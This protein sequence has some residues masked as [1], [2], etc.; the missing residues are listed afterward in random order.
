M[1]I[2]ACPDIRR[3]DRTHQGAIA[4]LLAALIVVALIGKAAASTYVV[5]IPLD[6]PIYVE[7]DTLNGLGLLD[8]YLP[9][10]RPISRIEA[11]RLVLEARDNLAREG[12][13]N[14][15]A[16]SLIARLRKQLGAE[17]SW[18][19]EDGEDN[20]PNLVHPF[21]R[22]EFG[23]LFSRGERRAMDNNGGGYIR[24][25]EATALLANGDGLSAKGEHNQTGR[26]SLWQ[27]FGGFFTAYG[28]GAVSGSLSSPGDSSARMLSG[29]AV[30]SLGNLAL[31]F[32]REEMA[33]GVGN[34]GQLSQSDNARPFPALRLR[35]IHADHLPWVFRYLGPYRTD[36]F[37]GQLDGARYFAH[38]FISGQAI[39][40]KPL[41]TFEMGLDHT[42]LFGGRHNDHYGWAGW[43]GRASGFAT[44][45][46]TVGN[47]NSRGGIFFRIYI[48][49]LRRLQLY[50]EI[51]GEDN[52]TAEVRPIGRFLPFLSV[53]YQG[54]V[55]LPDLT[56]DGRTTLRFEYTILEPNYS[57]H[58]DSLYWTYNGLLMGYPLGPDASRLDLAVGRW[59]D[60][61]DLLQGDLFYTERASGPHIPNWHKERSGGLAI[62]LWRLPGKLP[63]TRGI[64]C[65]L[66][67][68][69]AVEYVNN[70][71]FSTSG[72]FRAVFAISVSF[73]NPSGNWRW[74]L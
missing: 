33:W 71:N 5:E 74:R 11:A 23:Y 36:V 3:Q 15:L 22:V 16:H 48:P 72:A 57:T 39:V 25:R 40:F 10:I 18:V 28:E 24:A 7:L 8:T 69:A 37:I 43:L 61:R 42:I 12:S 55:Y 68:R 31:S 19:A 1:S 21:G 62:D 63:G 34:F 35:N 4:A 17:M 51:L 56:A 65:D 70:I 9:E 45:D 30:I 50:Q 13:H 54:G 41:P 38:P 52:L 47:T 29:A 67:L 64:L 2:S 49:R 44:G 73:T 26:W 59:L 66:H 27:G 60:D 6:S 46:P 53:S 20:L 32:G 14:D 58:S